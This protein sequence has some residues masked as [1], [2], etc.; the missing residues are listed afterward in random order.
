MKSPRQYHWSP[1]GKIG[2]NAVFHA[3]SGTAAMPSIRGV[4][5]ARASRSASDSSSPSCVQTSAQT[6]RRW[7]SSGNGGPGGT[8]MSETKPPSSSGAPAM[9]SPYQRMTSCVWSRSYITGPASTVL[10]G[11]H[12]NVNFVTTPKFP[13]P[14]RMAQNRSGSCSASHCAIDPSASTSDAASR[15]SIVR[16]SARVRWPMPPPSVSPPTPVV[17]ITPTGT[18]SACSWVAASRSFS[19]TPP[20]TCTT[21]AFGSTTISDISERST[22][23]PPSTLPSP[24]PLCP[25]PRTASVRPFDVANCTAA[26]TSASSRQ[27][28]I[29]A[30]RL[31][32]I[33][34]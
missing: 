15:L 30:G 28:T 27:Y 1:G 20:C 26:E 23:R 4:P 25:P 2:S 10:A 5:N 22:T 6:L 3:G 19:S 8:D 18:V 33:P 34:L 16:P 11:W 24:P 17:P 7:S 12:R 9:K 13:P 31:S 29:A 14:P 32:I 21:R